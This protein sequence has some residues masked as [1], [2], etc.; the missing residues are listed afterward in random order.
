MSKARRRRRRPRGD[1]LADVVEACLADGQLP[2]PE[3]LRALVRA[4]REARGEVEEV[5][6]LRRDLRAERRARILAVD[7]EVSRVF[8]DV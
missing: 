3:T 5:E 8:P 1:H 4:Y 7:S 6:R 2:R